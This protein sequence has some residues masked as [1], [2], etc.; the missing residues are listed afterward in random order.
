MIL[1]RT[2]PFPRAFSARPRESRL[3]ASDEDGVCHA[4]D[5]SRRLQGANIA[6][7]VQAG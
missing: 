1:S 6:I 5:L 2:S 7:V 4:G 3:E